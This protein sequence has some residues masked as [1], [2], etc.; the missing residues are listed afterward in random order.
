MIPTTI[1][2]CQYKNII[3]MNIFFPVC[4]LQEFLIYLVQFFLV[5]RYTQH[6]KTIFQSSTATACSQYDGVI[7]NTHILRINNFIG[8]YILQYAIL[9]YSRRMGKS[10]TPHDSLI[11]LYRHIHQT[12]YHATGGIYFLCTNVRFY[13]DFM[14]TLDNHCYFFKRRITCTFTNTINS[15]LHLTCTIQYPSHCISSSHT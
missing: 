2:S 12:R 6:R 13:L 5:K 10:I 7:I 11:R 4:K 15:H 1:S 9:M 8:L 3:I 14:M